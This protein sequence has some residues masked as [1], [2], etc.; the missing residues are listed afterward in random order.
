VLTVQ[1][2]R[3]AEIEFWALGIIATV[4]SGGRVE[5]S[6][7]E[8]KAEW[9]DPVKTARRLAG[10]ANAARGE[11]VLWL[12]G[13]D[14][15][16]G[17]VGI[18]PDDLATWWFSVISN[19]DGPNP[20]AT[21]VMIFQGSVTVL[22]LLLETASA[23][24]V[25]KN[26]SF[27][28]PSGGPV[29]LEVPW[30]EMTSVRTARHSD[31]IRL[32]V[33]QLRL[34]SIEVLDASLNGSRH[35]KS[36][37]RVVGDFGPGFKWNLRLTL[38]VVPRNSELLIFPAHLVSVTIKEPVSLGELPLH[39]YV[40]HGMIS[41][42]TTDL[43]VEGPSRVV[44]EASGEY[45]GVEAPGSQATV[46]VRLVPAGSDQRVVIACELKQEKPNLFKLIR[47]SV[48]TA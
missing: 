42:R 34:P 40:S 13:V 3:Q 12:L 5:D 1:V 20:S 39:F 32:L 33:P 37:G 43:A 38:Y 17:V 41:D 27:G 23:P 16:Q 36:T 11:D 8:L 10:H 7:V 46:T 15:R 21:P 14:E 30:R 18:N 44:I 48:S 19:F 2:M 22:A 4:T 26:P 45:E 28:T 6:R 47:S 29:A 35:E 31:L 25:V 9:P 24:F